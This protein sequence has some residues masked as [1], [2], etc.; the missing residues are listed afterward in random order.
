MVFQKTY[1][2]YVTEHYGADRN[3]SI[4]SSTLPN[5][6]HFRMAQ[7]NIHTGEVGIEEVY[8]SLQTEGLLGVLS[9]EDSGCEEILPACYI[10]QSAEQIFDI[11]K[12]YMILLSLR[13][14]TEETFRGHLL[15]SFVACCAVRMIQMRLK[16]AVLF[17]GSRMVCLRNQ[18]CTIDQNRIVT[19]E[20]QK[21]ANDSYKALGVTCPEGIPVQGGRLIYTPPASGTFSA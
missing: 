17:S 16:D 7:T 14:R 13:D 10:R 19:D 21:E 4:D 1:L 8:E 3:I 9:G 20:P 5:N 11:A 6:I 18:K 15:L 2:K 12:S